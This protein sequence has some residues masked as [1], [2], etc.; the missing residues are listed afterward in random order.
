[1]NPLVSDAFV[2]F[3]VADVLDVEGLCRLPKFEG[4]GKETIGP[5]FAACRRVA[6]E[7]LA[8]GYRAI[9]AEPPRL[10][11][12]RVRVH[13]KMHDAWRELVGLD[14]IAAVHQLPLTVTTLSSAYLMA[15]NLSAYGLA[16]L[17][18]GAAHLI[19]AFGSGAVRELFLSQLRSGEWA[20]TMALTE[21]QAG[22][23]L[24][25]VTTRARPVAEG[26]F[27]INGAKIFIS[28]GDQDLTQNVV[29]LV[30][31][32]IEGSPAGTKGISL[33]AVPRRRPEGDGLVDNDVHVS[34]VIHK[35][36][37]RGLPSL[38]LSF[39]DEGDCHG[40]LVGMPNQ[41]LRCMF[42][43]MNEAR[44]MVGV[45]AAAT[46]SV[47]FHESVAYAKDRK[48]GRALGNADASS[49]QVPLTA[50]ADVRRMLLRQKAIVEGSLALLGLTARFADLSVHAADEA[51]RTRAKWLLDLL[52]PI[53]K[54]FP[55]EKGFESNA[56]ALQVHGGYGYSS[57]YLP[58]AWLRDQ[59][60][61]TIHEGT[62]SIQG[63]DLLGRKVVAG[64]GAA[65]LALVDEMEPDLAKSALD[66]SVLR[67]AVGQVSEVTAA[68]GARGA[69]GDVEGM[70]GHSADFMEAMSVVVV[71]WVWT[72]LSN[73]VAGRDDDFSKGLRTAAQY[74]L[75][76]EVPRVDALLKLCVSEDRSYLDLQ[77]AWL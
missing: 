20:G 54:T 40:W 77:P 4:H 31:A 22:S 24:A 62:T 75:V 73:A 17:T 18:A 63:L 58:E 66:V 45:N 46:A 35:I 53:A 67:A 76:T 56:L 48:Q 38:A 42:Q 52:T 7:V 69:S 47:A 15:G 74:W 19:E 33:F 65:L 11:D 37:W 51:E 32:R 49:E 23:S 16:G 55:A 44:I 68:L 28:G 59:K 10:V 64:G 41:G 1:M 27:L 61:N 25:D 9:D 26:T 34:G 2:D 14:V 12:G 43:M 29:H 30:L 71:G 21:P 5:W 70:L 50:H 60:L 39:G 8:P 13:P 72:K 3:L 36:G 57:E 6:R